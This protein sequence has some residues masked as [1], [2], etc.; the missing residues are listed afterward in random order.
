M[1]EWKVINRDEPPEG[2]KL[3]LFDQ[4]VYT[5]FIVTDEET[6][7]ILTDDEGFPIWE[8]SEKPVKTCANVRYYADFNFPDMNRFRQFV[9]F[10]KAVAELEEKTGFFV[11]AIGPNNIVD[12]LF[13]ND[14]MTGK[15]Y[16]WSDADDHR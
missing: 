3:F 5:G 7:K 2:T 1:I 15:T 13:V 14:E 9:E 11:T 16:R 12:G 4:A 6:E 10:V 8:T